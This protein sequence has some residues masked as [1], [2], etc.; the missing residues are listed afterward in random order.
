MGLTITAT[1]DASR[2]A[3]A[4]RFVAA[5]YDTL[6]G[7]ATTSPPASPAT[8]AVSFA[9]GEF[10]RLREGIAARIGVR[11]GVFAGYG[12]TRPLAELPAAWHDLLALFELSDAGGELR[13]D[14]VTAVRDG[15]AR[16]LVE[17]PVPVTPLDDFGRAGWLRGA[18]D[19]LHAV[20]AAAAADGGEVEV[21]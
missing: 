2:A 9:Y 13:G 16:V 21:G 10:A 5:W 18:I 1:S 7:P 6:D 17:P 15:L 11:L 12:G 19:A 8:V 4:R 3:H 14:T 20:V